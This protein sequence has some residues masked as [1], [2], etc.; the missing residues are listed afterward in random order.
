MEC[1]MILM[2]K[3]CQEVLFIFSHQLISMKSSLYYRIHLY[4]SP[5]W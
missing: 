1:T 5:A 3:R 4:I 2:Y